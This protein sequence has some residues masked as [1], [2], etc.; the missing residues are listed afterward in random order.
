V[1]VESLGLSEKATL[2]DLERHRLIRELIGLLVTDAVKSADQRIKE[3]KVRSVHDLQKLDHNVTGYSEDMHRRNRELKDF[4]YGNLYRHYRVVRMA[5]KAERI[6]SDLYHAYHSEPDMLPNAFRSLI[7]ERG[8]ER[9]ICDYLAGMT[10]RYA[11]QEY[12]R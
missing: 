12:E 8:L 4:L 10:D 5:I 9:T 3:A 1:L 7:E 6:L 2:A 11:L